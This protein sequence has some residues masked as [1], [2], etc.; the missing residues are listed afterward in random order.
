MNYKND[1]LDRPTLT[2]IVEAVPNPPA[3]MVRKDKRF[4]ELGLDEA[5][6]QTTEEVVDLLVEHGL[7]MQRPVIFRDDRAVIGRPP[8]TVKELLE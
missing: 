4:G 1:P 5:S 6:Y 3:D 8:E 7:L 2:R